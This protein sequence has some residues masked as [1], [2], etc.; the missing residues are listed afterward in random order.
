MSALVSFLGPELAA[1]V[2]SAAMVAGL[3]FA[4]YG[5]TVTAFWLVTQGLDLVAAFRQ[6]GERAGGVV[7]FCHRGERAGLPEQPRQTLAGGRHRP[8]LT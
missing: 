6:R 3:G 7:S 8:D 4:F 2:L 1:D 5:L